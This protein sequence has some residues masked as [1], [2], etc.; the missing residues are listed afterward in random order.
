M[1]AL[2]LCAVFFIASMDDILEQTEVQSTPSFGLV[3]PEQ[4]FVRWVMFLV[5]VSYWCP[6]KLR[7][8]VL[9]SG[10]VDHRH[11]VTLEDGEL[12][13]SLREIKLRIAITCAAKVNCFAM[14]WR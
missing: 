3:C 6:P 1:L 7:L 14:T 8:A 2:V 11:E 12:G 9:E 4:Y 10:T 5:E 13:L